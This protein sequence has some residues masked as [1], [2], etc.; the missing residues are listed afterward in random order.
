VVVEHA[1]GGGGAVAAPIARQVMQ[2]FFDL[3][4]GREEATY[5]KN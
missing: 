5:A 2:T 4:K 3:K 1:E